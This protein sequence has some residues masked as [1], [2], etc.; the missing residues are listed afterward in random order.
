MSWRLKV[1]VGIVLWV[2]SQSLH[3]WPWL[4]LNLWAL[5]AVFLTSSFLR[6]F[7][8][9]LSNLVFTRPLRNIHDQPDM[10]VKLHEKV[11]P[12]LLKSCFLFSAFLGAHAFVQGFQSWQDIG[13][14]VIYIFR[15]VHMVADLKKACSWVMSTSL[16]SFRVCQFLFARRDS[17]A[18]P[19]L[20]GIYFWRRKFGST[21]SNS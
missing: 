9:G 15:P 19:V 3:F 14:R 6:N 16:L 12:I 1:Y 20:K 4:S 5:Y 11:N 8:I 10:L 21:V 7:N 13:T 18:D 17:P 2:F